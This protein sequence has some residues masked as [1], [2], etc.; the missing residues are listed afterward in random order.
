MNLKERGKNIF[1][2]LKATYQEWNEDEPFRQSAVIA[3]YSIF[4]LPALLIIIVNTVGIVLGEEAVQGNIS[5]QISDLVGAEAAQQVEEMIANV[6]QQGNNVI[7]IIIGIG[8]L[9]FGA[10]GVFYQLQQSLNK[11]WE[12]ELKPNAGYA[13]LAIDRA[14]SLGVILAIGF[15][16]LVSLALTAVL[17]ALGGWIERQLPDFMLYL[18]QLI[19]LFVPF[20]VITLL[21]ALIY[22]V[23]PD[24]KISWHAV[25]IGALVTALLFTIGKSAIGFYFGTSNPASAFGAAGS[26][27]LILLWVNYSALIFLFGAEFTQVY[28]RRYGE[29]IEPNSYA[30]RTAEFRIKEQEQREQ[31]QKEEEAQASATSE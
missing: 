18:F 22:K 6:S 5:A 29:R 28:A 13:K 23:L 25:W 21:F 11:V 26:V 15:L 24:V 2:L 4:S 16:L 9:L 8:T 10:T 20:G 31:L 17:T 1:S 14:T 3:Y 7:G 19:N 30:R 12:V 27:I